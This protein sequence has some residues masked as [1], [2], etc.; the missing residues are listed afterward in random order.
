MSAIPTIH[1]LADAPLP[2]D[3]VRRDVDAIFFET[4]PLAPTEPSARAAFYDLW[5]GQY[6]HH[7]PGLAFVAVAD[8]CVVGYVV[9]CM[10]DP[11]TSPRFA[12]LG[13]F[14]TFADAVQRF[15]A[16]LH[17]NLTA[18]ARGRGT[19]QALISRLCGELAPAGVPGVHVVTG[20]DARNVRFYARC[21]FR[22]AATTLRNGRSIVMLGR[23]LARG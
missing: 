12:S 5:L 1:A 4:A 14:Q 8:G 18:A 17:I 13:Y 6:L 7:E 10:A 19:G 2:P 3:T 9:G 23:T 16:H 15:P 22:P 21:G 20:A 11:V